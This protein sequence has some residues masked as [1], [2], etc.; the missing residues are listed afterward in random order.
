MTY[1]VSSGTLNITIPYC[2]GRDKVKILNRDDVQSSIYE[3]S[4][5]TS[6]KT[7]RYCIVLSVIDKHARSS[8]DDVDD[9]AARTASVLKQPRL[10]V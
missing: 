5:L 10:P 7:R 6:R 9:D 4:D 1:N 2:D 8:D 3:S